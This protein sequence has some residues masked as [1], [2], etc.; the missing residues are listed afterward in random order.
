MRRR[1]PISA[2]RRWL[3]Q[4]IVGLVTLPLSALPIWVYA[5]HTPVGQ[6]LSMRVRYEFFAPA[7][8]HLDAHAQAIAQADRRTSFAGVPVL[9]YSLGHPT[10]SFDG[11]YVV[12]RTNFAEQMRALRAAGYAPDQGR[13]A[14]PVH[15]HGL[16]FRAAA[17]AGPDHVRRRHD[18]V[19]APGR[20]RSSR[21]PACA[22]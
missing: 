6:L 21:R 9:L 14:R 8:P 1:K 7:T 20:P 13:A 17:Q 18:R 3:L 10:E 11:R 22:R 4:S 12:S 5:T 16:P 19:D 15:A 2:R